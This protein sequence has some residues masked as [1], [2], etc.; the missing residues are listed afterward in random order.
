M[1][2]PEAKFNGGPSGRQSQLPFQGGLEGNID[3]SSVRSLGS[4]L[5]PSTAR[6]APC[7]YRFDQRVNDDGRDTM[8]ATAIDVT[9]IEA[10]HLQHFLYN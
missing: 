2:N 10:S 4:S 1:Q 6:N 9:A 5:H 7:A 3:H 8:E